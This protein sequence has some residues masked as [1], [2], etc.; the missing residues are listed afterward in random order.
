MSRSKR[1]LLVTPVWKG[2][3]GFFCMRALQQMGHETQV[4]DY[5]ITA[6]GSNE[7]QQKQAGPLQ[8]LRNK[9]G[10][11]WMNHVLRRTVKQFAPDIVLVIKGEI[12]E[13]RTLVS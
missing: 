1:I 7:Y 10:V 11:A 6:Y 3:L 13:D 12:I 9:A 8:I 5:R 4:F 2:S